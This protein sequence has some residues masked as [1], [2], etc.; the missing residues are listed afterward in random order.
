MTCLHD[1]TK[2]GKDIPLRYGSWQS[3]VCRDCG[4]FQRRGHNGYVIDGIWLPASNYEAETVERDDN[5]Y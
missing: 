2:R 1:N 5:D 4:A 3:L